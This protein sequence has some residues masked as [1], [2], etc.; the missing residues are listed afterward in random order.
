MK[1]N[2]RAIALTYLKHSES[3]IITKLFTEENGLQTFIVRNVRA[4]KAKIKLR[5]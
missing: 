4:K 2:S 5:L 3:S 1:Y